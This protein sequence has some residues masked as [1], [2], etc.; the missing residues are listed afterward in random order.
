MAA[1]LVVA[2]AQAG[3][4]PQESLINVSAERFENLTRLARRGPFRPGGHRHVEDPFAVV[5]P[6][7]TEPA[8]G[9]LSGG[10]GDVAEHLLHRGRR[11]DPRRCPQQ[12]VQLFEMLFADLFRPLAVRDVD[13]RADGAAGL[14]L[15]IKHRLEAGRSVP[16]RP[17]GLRRRVGGCLVN[18]RLDGGR[19]DGGRLV[20]GR[21]DRGFLFRHGRDSLTQWHSPNRYCAPLRRSA[22]RR[23]RA[24]F[25]CAADFVSVFPYNFATGP[26]A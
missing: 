15:G 9:E 16:D 4:V 17:F 13:K 3:A 23:R 8:P 12:H 14:S 6:G 1:E 5:V 18:K 19:L 21:L 22:S 7:Q 10:V 20:G 25:A 26:W 11:E 24:Y 2:Q